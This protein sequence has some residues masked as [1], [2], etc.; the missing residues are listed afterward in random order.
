MELTASDILHIWNKADHLAQKNLILLPI[1]PTIDINKNNVIILNKK[2][3]QP[4]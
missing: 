2:I 1:D 4:S 3:E